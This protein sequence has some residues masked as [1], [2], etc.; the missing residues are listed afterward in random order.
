[1]IEYYV[2]VAV[3]GFLILLLYT[4]FIPSKKPSK[5]TT[6][7]IEGEKVTVYKPESF[8]ERYAGLS[9]FSSADG[10]N[11]LLL[12]NV[13]SVVMRNMSFP[14]VAIV[15]QDNTVEQIHE[16]EQPSNLLEYYLMYDSL[17][18]SSGTVIE[19]P[20]PVYEKINVDEGNEV[21][22]S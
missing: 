10:A 3:A 13:D 9:R 12:G 20:K 16:L 15:V 6:V 8:R 1:M 7:K 21:R 5:T 19:L 17:K 18:V 14:I 4:G 11:G 22:F 2:I